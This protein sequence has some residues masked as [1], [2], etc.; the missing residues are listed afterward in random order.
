M[1]VAII[2]S[3]VSGLTAAYA[4]R[5]THE[6]TLFERDT[7]LGGHAHTHT[8]VNS[9]GDTDHIDSGFI[10]HNDRTYPTL[11][12]IFSELSIAT[13]DT[14][15]SMSI[16]CDGCGLAYAGGRGAKGLFAQRGRLL[17]ARY[18]RMLVEVPRFHREA[19][20]L[21]A[22]NDGSNPTW[23]QFLHDGGY[24]EYF[25]HHFAIPLVSCVWSSGDSDTLRYPARHLFVFLQH[26]GLLS[27]G[28]SPT[29][30]T[31]VGGSATY[32]AAITDALPDVRAHRAVVAVQ[33]H[34]DGVEITTDDGHTSRFDQV[35][36]ATHAN[37]AL[38]LLMDA[39]EQERRDLA[40]IPYS[41]NETWLHHDDSV[42]PREA[43]ARGSWN[44]RM[45]GCAT[46][47][48]GVLVSYWMNHL[49][50]ID[51][52]DEYLVT[53]NPRGRVREDGI[54]ARMQYEHP[55]FTN[56]AVDA[57]SRLREAGGPRL[58]F[59]G[60]HLGWGFHEDGARSGIAA[61][62]KFGAQW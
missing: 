1:S 28:H 2:G 52:P 31:V 32:V 46:P 20:A 25:I 14:E 35:I 58:A 34:A 43:G 39:D 37:E 51:S 36:I 24:S 10:V 40:A 53:L 21:L 15:M 13:R 11:L 60:A 50:R 8:V 33:R 26:H 62:R 16:R 23:G 41:R 12:R 6:V 22:S 54:I 47:S 7:R 55:V 44:Y 56:E 5:S 45:A 29:W 4:L 17:D 3:G 57:A 38:R 61:A 59:A 30:R 49:H 27:V 42:L 18:L 19:K 48:D 9:A